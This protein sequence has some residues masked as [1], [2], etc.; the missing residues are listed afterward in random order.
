MKEVLIS[1]RYALA[2]LKLAIENNSIEETRNALLRFT[3]HVTDNR[4]VF[5][6]LCDE[7]TPKSKRQ[8]LVRELSGALLLGPLVPKFIEVLIQKERI[9]N[10]SRISSIFNGLADKELK[11]L[12]GFIFGAD[13]LKINEIGEKFSNI[14]A[15]KTKNK[16][17]LSSKIDPSLIG[18]LK[19]QVGSTV[20]DASVSRKLDE[21][22]ERLCR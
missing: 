16:V 15:V 20:W 21:L 17:V 4:K 22:K 5:L 1:K 7:E 8:S 12:R 19:I 13:E 18:G 14:L 6:W 11:I 2:L 3:E 10:I 9:K